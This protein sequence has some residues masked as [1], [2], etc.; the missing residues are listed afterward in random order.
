M[1]NTNS[2]AMGIIPL[3][4]IILI[5]VYLE[6]FLRTEEPIIT[7]NGGVYCVQHVW[8]LYLRLFQYWLIM[9]GSDMENVIVLLISLEKIMSFH[10]VKS[11]LR[12]LGRSWE[13]K[14]C[15]GFLY[16]PFK[17]I[18]VSRV[19]ENITFRDLICTAVVTLK[20]QDQAS[21]FVFHHG[22]LM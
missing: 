1:E 17:A 2:D 14:T 13:L 12:N 8:C 20:P 22:W 7:I 5:D 9:L 6:V 3:D 15:S 18:C 16:R 11:V 21:S 19:R 4:L 10:P